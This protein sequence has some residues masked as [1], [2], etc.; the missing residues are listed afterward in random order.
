MENNN[1]ILCKYLL[2]SGACRYV[3]CK[4]ELFCDE[5]KK[6]IDFVKENNIPASIYIHFQSQSVGVTIFEKD[7]VA[8]NTG[9]LFAD[10]NLQNIIKIKNRLKEWLDQ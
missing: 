2:K 10:Y 1:C 7:V 4:T 6:I 9:T 3:K 8:F 5:V